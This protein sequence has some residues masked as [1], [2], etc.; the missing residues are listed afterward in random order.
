MHCDER[1]YLCGWIVS[2]GAISL[3]LLYMCIATGS[4]RAEL[5]DCSYISNVKGRKI[6]LDKVRD[7]RAKTT[8]NETPSADAIKAALRMKFEHAEPDIRELLLGLNTVLCNS[9]FP[10]TGDDFTESTS[11][12]L[13]DLSVLL[14]VWG[15]VDS[16]RARV[17]YEVIPIRLYEHFKGNKNLSGLYNAS[18]PMHNNDPVAQNLF[19]EAQELRALTALALGI[20]YEHIGNVDPDP[21]T[22]TVSYDT[23]KNCFCRAKLILEKA[24]QTAVSQDDRKQLVDYAAAKAEGVSRSAVNY[25]VNRSYRGSM[26]NNVSEAILCP[27]AD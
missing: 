19:S 8:M 13:D 22:R 11:Q 5:A 17:C 3:V 2:A 16:H 7:N 25:S 27:S 10:E 4:A 21:K 9:R 14:E 6:V 24:A 18:Y 20:S 12:L 26:K 23:A 1:D 15:D